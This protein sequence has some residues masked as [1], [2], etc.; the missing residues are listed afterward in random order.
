MAL[1]DSTLSLIAFKQ[2]QGKSMTDINKGVGNE[3]EGIKLNVDS[4][5]IFVNEPDS[6]PATAMLMGVAEFMIGDL[7]LDGTSNSQAYFATYAIGHP[8][9]GQRVIN[10]ISPTYGVGYEAKPFAGVNPIPVNDSIDWIYQYQSGI[11]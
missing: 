2:L 7:T 8:K 6:S 4:S 5:T 11:F 3:G 1:L 9:A 10:A